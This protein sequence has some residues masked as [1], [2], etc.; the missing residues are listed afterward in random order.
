MIEIV[1]RGVK[2]ESETGRGRA[3]RLVHGEDRV[4]EK[5]EEIIYDRPVCHGR[6]ER[7]DGAAARGTLGE[8]QGYGAGRDG[9]DDQPVHRHDGDPCGDKGLRGRQI[10]AEGALDVDRTPIDVAAD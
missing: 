7:L 9:G 6:S 2:A 1:T 5:P 8:R 10:V 3:G 4:C